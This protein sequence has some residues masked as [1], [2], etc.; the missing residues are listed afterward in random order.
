MKRLLLLILAAPTLVGSAVCWFAAAPMAS[1]AESVVQSVSEPDP[2]ATEPQVCVL[3]S[4]SQTN[5]VCDR[6]SNLEKMPKVEPVDFATDPFES[7]IEFEFSVSEGN[8]A[9]ALFGCDC[10]T[11]INALRNLRMMAG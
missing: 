1:A 10:S 3:S 9:I 5:L 6:V 2:K 8:A 11:C 4:H 7:P